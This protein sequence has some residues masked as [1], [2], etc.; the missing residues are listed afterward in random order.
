VAALVLAAGHEAR[1]LSDLLGSLAAAARDQAAMQ[2]R[3]EAGRARTRTS[4]RVVVGA[5]LVFAAG[6]LLLNRSY[7]SPFGT[8]VGQAMLGVIG[9]LFAGAFWWLSRLARPA[10]PERFLAAQ[11]HSGTP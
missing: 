3:V 8:P 6:L 7:L 2:L 11:T 9:L 1:R 4:S 5:T 10:P